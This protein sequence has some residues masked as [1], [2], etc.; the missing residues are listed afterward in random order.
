MAIRME[1]VIITIVFGADERWLDLD[2]SA[3]E[4]VGVI[5]SSLALDLQDP[6]RGE[7]LQPAHQAFLSHADGT[8]VDSGKTLAECSLWDGTILFLHTDLRSPNGAPPIQQRFDRAR[9]GKRASEPVSGWRDI[10]N[11]DPED[12]D[13]A[14]KDPLQGYVWKRLDD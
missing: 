2:V 8:P 11:G 14:G 4:R 13:K 6:S 5:A 9:S 7:I 3:D 10:G 12:R 1:R